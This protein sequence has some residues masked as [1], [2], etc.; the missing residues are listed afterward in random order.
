MTTK[1]VYVTDDQINELSEL[2]HL[3]RMKRGCDGLNG[4]VWDGCLHAAIEDLL[5]ERE[6]K[7]LQ[8]GLIY[9][10]DYQEMKDGIKKLVKD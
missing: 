3:Y 6:Q 4:R 9:P 10:V 1:A 5:V 2:L 8:D 7:L